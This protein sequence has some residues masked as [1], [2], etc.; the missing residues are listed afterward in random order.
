MALYLVVCRG[1]EKAGCGEVEEDSLIAATIYLTLARFLIS[2]RVPIGSP[3]R[4][5]ETFTSHL[6]DPFTTMSSAHRQVVKLAA[7]TVS[8]FPSLTPKARNSA[9]SVRTYSAASSVDLKSGSVTISSRPVPALLRSMWVVRESSS[10][11]DFAVS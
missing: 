8:I 9:C 6:R 7:H 3:G 2:Q 11:I 5:I 4:F 10:D 1:N